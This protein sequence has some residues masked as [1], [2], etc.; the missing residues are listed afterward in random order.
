MRENG[1]VEAAGTIV[2][3]LLLA[4]MSGAG[5]VSAGSEDL[6]GD[7][8]L[9]KEIWRAEKAYMERLQAGD[10]EGLSGFWH[11]DFAGW[12]SHA[13]EPV[14]IEAGQASMRAL[15][16]ELDMVS[17]RIRPLATRSSGDAVLVHY[18]L[19]AELRG[20]DGAVRAARYRIIHTW[21]RDGEAWKILG[22]MSAEVATG[23]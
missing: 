4:C 1:Q 8:A 19:E 3:C 7:D 17:F 13:T 16:A 5:A 10:V 18:L 22:G 9:S 12:P 14:G 2:V 6:E 11:S 15:L 20:E 21:V 23:E